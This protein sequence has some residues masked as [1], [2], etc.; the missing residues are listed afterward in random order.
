MLAERVWRAGAP[1]D[2]ADESVSREFVPCSDGSCAECDI[3]GIELPG[4][5]KPFF[6]VV[7]FERVLSEK[8]PLALGADATRRMNRDALAPIA[9]GE[10]GPARVG[11]G[12]VGG[13]KES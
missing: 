6:V 8:R 10:S 3:G 4:D 5:S 1:R 9:L 12:G 13:M 2:D 11:V 7:T